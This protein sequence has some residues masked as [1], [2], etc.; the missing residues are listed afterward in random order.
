MKGTIFAAA[1]L[2]FVA[3]LTQ[4]ETQ[5]VPAPQAR[6]AAAS[7]GAQGVV[8]R[9]CET[10]HNG[11][12]RAGGLALDTLT[13]ADA[14]RESQ[15]WEKVVRKLRTGMMPPS[16]APRPDRATLD[17]LAAT[18]ENAL[19]RAAA[20]AP[21]PGA[22]ALHRLAEIVHGAGAVLRGIGQRGTGFGQHVA[23]DGPERLADLNIRAHR[24]FLGHVRVL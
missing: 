24:R 12:T 6:A 22:P 17:S 10:C 13:V 21:N 14:H 3:G 16:G 23:G 11:R 15:T 9:Y 8:D 20:A 2:L 7:S 18:V 19:D 5:T 1:A 4:V